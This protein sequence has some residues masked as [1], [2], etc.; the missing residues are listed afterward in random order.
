M[1]NL[2]ELNHVPSEGGTDKAQLKYCK[3]RIPSRSYL[4]EVLC[5][6]SRQAEFLYETAN[7]FVVFIPVYL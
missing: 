5:T 6:N 4:A 7:P 3:V 1:E 2:F